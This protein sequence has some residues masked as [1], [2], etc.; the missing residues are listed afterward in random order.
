[1]RHKT[2]RLWSF[3]TAF[4]VML[5]FMSFV[6]VKSVQAYT[7]ASIFK[8]VKVGLVS[9]SSTNLAAV[10]NGDYTLNGIN[11]PTGTLLTFKIS[12]GLINVNGKDYLEVQ[13]QP[14]TS[15][16]FIA[17]TSGT[18]TYKYY[19]DFLFKV[20]SGKILPINSLDIETYLKGVVGYEMSDYF[21]IEAL[22][23]QAVAARN[24]ALFKLGAEA[25]KGYDFDDT[26]SYQ[27]YKGFDENLKNVIRAVD[28]TRFVVLLYN[29]K[30]VEAL[31]SAWHGGYTEEGVNVWGSYYPYFKA[32]VD[33][34]EADPWPNGN[35]VFTNTQ[36]DSTL[37][38]RGWLLSTDTFMQLDLSSITRFTSSRVASINIIYRDNLG[39]TKTKTVTKDKARTFLGLPSSM[40]TV[41]YNSTTGTYTF[42]GKGYGHGLG[43]SQIGAKNRAASGQTYEQILKFYYDGSYL[44]NLT[45]KASISSFTL[46][47]TE[48]YTMD[49]VNIS[50]IGTG[51]SGEYLYKYQILKDGIE[52]KTTDF[53]ETSTL[54]YQ[55]SEPGNYE[56][57]SHIKDKLSLLTY[58]EKQSKILNVINRP[59]SLISSVNQSASQILLGETVSFEAFSTLNG[60]YKFDVIKDSNI[61]SSGTFGTTNSFVYTATSPGTYTLKIYSKHPESIN[62]FDDSRTMSFTVF[63]VPE[64]SVSQSGNGAV[65]TGQQI[66]FT[67]TATLGSG[68][69]LYKYVITNN[70]LIVFSNN[71]ST[72]NTLSYVP[73]KSG[74]YNVSVY[75]KDLASTKEFNDTET[76]TFTSYD[77]ME[78]ASAKTIGKMYKNHPIT[79]SS[80]LLGIN[81][82]GYSFKYQ[83]ALNGTVIS[84]QS[85]ASASQFSF[86]PTVAGKYTINLYVKSNIS[87]NSFDSVKTFSI[88]VASAPMVVST[89]PISYGMRGTDVATIQSGLTTLGYSPGVIDGI[90]GSKTYS[91]VI[92]FQKSVSL[93]ATGSV[94]VTTFNAMNNALIS[95]AEIKTIYY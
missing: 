51:G 69:Y 84:E 18:T 2:R 49:T 76:L 75:L 40:Y 85:I 91:A 29:D 60:L 25:S 9:M 62:S 93:K 78:I 94:D 4:I 74:V 17:L 26:I 87:K 80:D 31:Y 28:E 30:L 35:R 10:L 56:V 24:Y 55:A 73:S 38:A 44:E 7:N 37:K 19:G 66:D 65:I 77:E 33:S 39:V 48:M 82:Y 23:A 16:D 92:N 1:M 89:L 61:V 95:I 47:Q 59:E 52:V 11:Q 58:D 50:T 57:I 22:K 14:K 5:S 8:S 43:M 79:I 71:F 90:Y 20:T 45:P 36:I 64:V 83:I 21:P 53:T 70:D 3:V 41:Q 34:S 42:S 6:S 27:V 46:N 72:S 67:S 88:D 81:G 32:K 68:R 15:S 13:L 86:T 63:S 54:A 12:N